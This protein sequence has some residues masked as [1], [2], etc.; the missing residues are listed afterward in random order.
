MRVVYLALQA[1]YPPNDGGRIRTWNLLQAA[2]RAHDVTFLAFAR[3]DTGDSDLEQLRAICRDVRVVPWPEVPQP[4]LSER[5]R[6]LSQRMPMAARLARS[7]DMDRALASALQARDVD[8]I[9]VDHLYLAP[10]AC[11]CAC[12]RIMNHSDVEAAQQRRLLWTDS[13][14]FSAY[15]WLKW[16]EHLLWRSFE[17][18]SL[19]WFD[20]H[21]AVS[22]KDASYF[23][24]HARGLPVHVVPNGVDVAGIRFSPATRRA[25]VLLFVGRMDYGPNVDAV[26]W[27][28]RQ[29]F[30]SISSAV[31]DTRLL[32]VGRDPPDEVLRLG[33][34]GRVTVT[35]TVADVQPYYRE[36][37]VAVAPLRA[38][39]GT[40]LKILEA[41]AAGVPVIST[42]VG[43]EGLDVAPGRHLLV[44][45]SA[46][47]F[48]AQTIHLLN[49]APERERLAS[50]ARSLV[51]REFTWTGAGE[52]L[53]S[54]YRLAY[55]R[56]SK[57]RRPRAPRA[58]VA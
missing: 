28:C 3:R 24:R 30:P 42:S 55:E 57:G 25:H 47:A 4:T 51:E 54:A 50:S 21:I 56:H 7:S 9:H 34:D 32:I 46:Q 11:V 33:N 44:A 13:K 19:S 27:F 41:M 6:L 16:Q 52:S 37:A 38:G 5:A 29:V 40:R 22:G 2:G 45:D 12:A 48:A 58:V 26:L 1:P 14:R 20:A 39:G 23:R 35:G 36:A 31:P 49:N 8:L 53:L 18:R 15:W 43:C 10:Y 17:I